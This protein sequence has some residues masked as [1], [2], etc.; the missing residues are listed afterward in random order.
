[1]KGWEDSQ[2][3]IHALSMDKDE[4]SLSLVTANKQEVDIISQHIFS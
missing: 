1:M 4:G 2:T 3:D